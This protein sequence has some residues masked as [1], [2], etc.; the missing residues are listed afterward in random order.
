MR[1]ELRWVIPENSQYIEQAHLYAGVDMGWIKENS[2]TEKG[3][4]RGVAL[5]VRANTKRFDINLGW[6]KALT[7]PSFLQDDEEENLLRQNGSTV[8]GR[9]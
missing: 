5:G 3:H 8:L 2:P 7:S 1:N 9:L 6:E 4:M